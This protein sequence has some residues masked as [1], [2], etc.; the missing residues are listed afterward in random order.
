MI[1]CGYLIL[2]GK[3]KKKKKTKTLEYKISPRFSNSRNKNI[4]VT[5]NLY[6]WNVSF[7]NR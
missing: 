4:G 3:Q 6:A 2:P 1:N 7:D 5:Q